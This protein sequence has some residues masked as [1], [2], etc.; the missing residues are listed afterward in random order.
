V[1]TKTCK[2][3]SDEHF[4]DE[5]RPSSSRPL[6]RT[7]PKSLDRE[8][9]IEAYRDPETPDTSE[10]ENAQFLLSPIPTEET[11]NP[12]PFNDIED[13]TTT[14]KEVKLRA[15]TDFHGAR[16]LTTKFLQEV[17]M[18]MRANAEI[19]NTE[20][21]KVLFVLSFM[22]GGVAGSWKQGKTAAYLNAGNFGT[23]D[24]FKQAVKTAFTPID[25]GGVA[26]TE[27][28]TLRQGDMRIEEYIAQFTI[29][30][31]RTGLTK[32]SALIE[33]FI[34]GLHPKLMERVYTME[35]PP[36]TLEGWM[37]AASL[38][39]GNCRRARAIANRNKSGSLKPSPVPDYV[40]QMPTRDLN[41]MD[42]DTI[43]RLSPEERLDHIKKGL[44][45]ICHKPGHLSST[46]K[47]GGSSTTP[48]NFQR[49]TAYQR[50]RTITDELG[51]EE[52]DEIAAQMEKEG[53]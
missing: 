51:E 3:L 46:H 6:P 31:A 5:G 48:R 20:E 27:L 11:L 13:M 15:P 10:A 12:F 24:E 1:Y 41:A 26:K 50:I 34:D 38:F 35:K 45:F 49:K 44:C 29:I 36:T 2:A 25:D 37:R 19:Y 32:D 18:Y 52:K 39:D 28:R 22:N 9:S 23:F 14:T 8:L 42:I 21:K 17:E 33:Y 47:T 7:T 43:K 16:E 40:P 53:F 4:L 30:S